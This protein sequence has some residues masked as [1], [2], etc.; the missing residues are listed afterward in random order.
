MT[1]V[2]A[3]EII[4][5]LNSID[6]TLLWVNVLLGFLTGLVFGRIIFWRQ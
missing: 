2:Q 3:T 6:T 4:E 1:E 5:I